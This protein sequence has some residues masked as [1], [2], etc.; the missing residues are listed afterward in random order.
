MLFESLPETHPP[1]CREEYEP[2]HPPDAITTNLPK[3]KQSVS[4]PSSF[5]ADNDSSLSLAGGKSH[6]STPTSLGPVDP[7]TISKVV[8]EVT[9]EEKDR[10]AL[11]EARPSLSECLNLHD[12]EARASLPTARPLVV[13]LNDRTLNVRLWLGKSCLQ[14]L[15]RTIVRRPMMRL[16]TVKTI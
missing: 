12:F 5:D 9:Q 14:R 15:G 6:H 3:E 4:F 10:L 11:F 16:R 13:N 2:I 1:I 8:K 7:E